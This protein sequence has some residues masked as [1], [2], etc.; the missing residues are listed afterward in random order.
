[1]G[2]TAH[3]GI[4]QLFK[5]NNTSI[6]FLDRRILAFGCIRLLLRQQNDAG[7]FIV[8]FKGFYFY[9]TTFLFVA[10]LVSIIVDLYAPYRVLMLG[11][12]K[13]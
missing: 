12:G 13:K 3:F 4:R 6:P 10:T 11:K 5:K 2:D 1:M 8:F 9:G 7:Q